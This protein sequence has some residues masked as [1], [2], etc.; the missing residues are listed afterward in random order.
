MGGGFTLGQ[1]VDR[2]QEGSVGRAVA[3]IDHNSDFEM[4]EVVRRGSCHADRLL[5]LDFQG[6]SYVKTDAWGFGS[7]RFSGN[8]LRMGDLD[9]DN[10]A[11]VVVGTR[12]ELLWFRPTR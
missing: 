8:E 12:K 9:G 1:K 4:L 5:L 6:D 11:D 2:L 7:E 10:R 3:N